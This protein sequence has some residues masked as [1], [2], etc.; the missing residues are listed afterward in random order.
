MSVTDRQTDAH[1]KNNILFEGWGEGDIIITLS[2]A[3]M[4]NRRPE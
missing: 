4:V 3:M 1:G 2:G